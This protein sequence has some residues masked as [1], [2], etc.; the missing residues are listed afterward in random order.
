MML[1]WPVAKNLVE[2][3]DHLMMAGADRALIRETKAAINSGAVSFESA[4]ESIAFGLN[5]GTH[6]SLQVA[7]GEFDPATVA[8]LLI[9]A[10]RTQQEA[11]ERIRRLRGEEN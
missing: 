11:P 10:I 1:L 4:A 2:L 5:A 9:E 7:H 8:R 3:E 6:Q